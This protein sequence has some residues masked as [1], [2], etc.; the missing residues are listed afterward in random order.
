MSTEVAHCTA[1]SC[2]RLIVDNK[3]NWLESRKL[4]QAATPDSTYCT[5]T[6]D[7]DP[8]CVRVWGGVGWGQEKG[9]PLATP[10]LECTKF[11]RGIPLPLSPPNL[12]QHQL[13]I[14][15]SSFILVHVQTYGSMTRLHTVTCCLLF[16]CH[17]TECTS[18]YVHARVQFNEYGT[19]TG[20]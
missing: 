12:S 11:R 15:Q 14:V 6:I 1:F 16:S 4:R 7:P 13:P 19:Y 18:S 8:D 20:Q 5:Y 3:V 2:A 17:R 10:L 9:N